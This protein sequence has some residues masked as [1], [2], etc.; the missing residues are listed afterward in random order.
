MTKFEFPA[1]KISSM[2]S[3]VTWSV[4]TAPS[5]H[6]HVA[7]SRATITVPALLLSL[8]AAHVGG[9][10]EC[11]GRIERDGDHQGDQDGNTRT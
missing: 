9:G 8:T 6:I 3:S 5:M 7:D 11:K 1:G 10:G 4:V 2:T